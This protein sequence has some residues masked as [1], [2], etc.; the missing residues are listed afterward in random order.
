MFFSCNLTIDDV[1]KDINVDN[2]LKSDLGYK[3]LGWKKNSPNYL[4]NF[5][6]DVFIM[7]IQFK[8]RTFFIT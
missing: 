6:K 2:M 3:K 1:P 8:P 4:N 5:H 7:V